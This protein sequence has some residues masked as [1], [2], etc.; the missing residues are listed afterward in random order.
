MSCV[1]CPGRSKIKNTFTVKKAIVG[2]EKSE[3][4]GAKKGKGKGRKGPFCKHGD[5]Y[6]Y[7]DFG[8]F[9]FE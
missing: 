1:L 8:H 6:S 4:Q 7:G 3:S 2:A 5:L 9:E